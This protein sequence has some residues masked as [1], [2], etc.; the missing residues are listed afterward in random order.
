MRIRTACR[1]LT[2]RLLMRSYC[3]DD[4]GARRALVD[5]N[6]A[7]LRPWIPWMREEPMSLPATRELLRQHAAAFGK[8]E[9]FRYPIFE[10]DS[11][12][13][14]GETGL[15]PRIGPGGLEA[16]YL[17]GRNFAGQGFAIEAA[18]A[19][20]RIAFEV[21]QVDRVQMHCDPANTA[22]V[23]IPRQLGFGL[24]DIIS[25]R[26]EDQ[27]DSG[28]LMIWVLPREDYP[29]SAAHGVAVKAYDAEGEK[30]L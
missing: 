14:I 12:A 26:G 28:E 22:S 13:M 29:N 23:K 15:Y 24:R 6:D 11:G 9:L 20:I 17:L 10:R 2:A 8:R 19:M 16:G 4:A 30:L 25:Q 7:W 21:E 18:S 3:E 5:A 1:V 27:Y